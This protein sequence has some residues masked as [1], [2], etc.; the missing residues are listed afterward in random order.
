MPAR[1]L[2]PGSRDTRRRSNAAA[3]GRQV[4]QSSPASSF[5]PSGGPRFQGKGREVAQLCELGAHGD[6]RFQDLGNRAAG[7]GVFGSFLKSG[8]VTAGNFGGHVEVNGGNGKTGF[9]L[10]ERQGGR[11]L[12]A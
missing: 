5:S 4:W 10:F 7:F 6:V 8:L 3:T 2:S 1:C 11:G 12:D 9:E